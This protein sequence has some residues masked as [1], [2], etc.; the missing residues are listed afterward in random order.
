MTIDERIEFSKKLQNYHYF[1]RSF[2]DIG[3]PIVA[4]FPDLPTAA[5]SFDD[6]GE[7]INFLINENFWNEL[8][9]C[10]KLFLICH[11]MSH[12]IFNHG[13]RFVE[14]INTNKFEKMNYAADVVIN[15]MLCDSFGFDRYKLDKRISENGCWLDT[16]FKDEKNIQPNESTEYY[17]NRIPDDI[18]S[19]D[20]FRFD[21]HSIGSSELEKIEK[22]LE[23]AGVADCIGQELIDRLPK[24]CQAG[25]GSGSWHN[26]QVEAKKKKKWESV[27]K[28]WENQFKKEVIDSEERW[29]RVNPRYSQIIKNDIMLPSD[30]KLLTETKE[31][32]KIN[33]FF[34]LDTSG[35][36]IG[37]AK[38]FFKAA[39]SLDPKK[40][41]IRLFCFDTQV[42]E[43]TLESGKIY[44]GGGTRFDIMEQHIQ[45]I[46]KKENIKYPKAVFVITDGYGTPI[47]PEKPKNWYWFLTN[48]YKQCIPKESK[49][50]PLKNYE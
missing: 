3:N 36:C 5:I 29:E 14:Y 27:I 8:N 6:D 9:E 25:I 37:Y 34:F 39:K 1:F 48:S 45:Y 49:V 12:I 24:E 20:I 44:G 26:I 41:N 17:F 30:I 40:F 38:R 50:F 35:S 7:C 28:K 32:E 31:K 10:T 43:T 11:E 47:N 42:K 16:V 21:S 23:N 46:L 33:V 19:K 15:E 2:W 4:D 18:S 13:E 22:V